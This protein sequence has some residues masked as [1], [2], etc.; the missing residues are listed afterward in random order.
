MGLLGSGTNTQNGQAS[1]LWLVANQRHLRHNAH[2][3]YTV[4]LSLA[5]ISQNTVPHIYF[6]SKEQLIDPLPPS[7]IV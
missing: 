2:P 5:K 6:S 1:T 7:K 4:A 3:F